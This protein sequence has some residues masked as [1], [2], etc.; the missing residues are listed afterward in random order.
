MKRL[1]IS[2]SIIGIVA[3][4]GIGVTVA[5]FNDTETSSGNIFVAGALD[6]KVDASGSYYN[7][8]GCSNG[9]WTC[10]PWA[11]QVVSFEQGKRKNGTPVV[12]A[13]SNPSAALGPADTNGNPYDSGFT[14][15]EFTA[16]GF[17]YGMGFGGVIVLKFDNIVVNGGGDDLM[18]YEVTGGSSYP[19]EKARVEVSQDG[20][21]W[22][23]LGLATRDKSFDLSSVGLAWVKYVRISDESTMGSFESTADGFDL[24]AVKALNCGT[25]PAVADMIGQQCNG[26]WALTDLSSQKF[27]NFEDVKP[28]DFGKNVVS[29]HL[30]DNNG[31]VCLVPH[32]L[33][34]AENVRLEP[35]EDAGDTSDGTLTNGELSQEINA[36]AWNDNDNDG[37]FE[38]NMGET[39]LYNDSFFNLFGTNLAIA[40]S[41]TGSPLSATTT[42]W[43]GLTWCAGDID[44]DS[45]WGLVSC[46]GSGMGDIAQTDSIAA[47]LSAYTEQYRNN[48][49]FLCSGIDLDSN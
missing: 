12:T 29:F 33:V 22:L 25:D 37:Y 10:E 36:L 5:L 2:F 19:D 26:S 34:D 20:N 39:L 13:R 15:S 47:S 14:E 45:T 1:I 41:D 35:E 11:D 16:L 43:I 8:L 48:P 7:G 4:V 32:D 31:W 9:G 18:V 38:P 28:G 24:D 46:D 42:K 40:D 49:N 6:L 23:D 17:D 44:Y 3:M 27:F 30:D 21:T